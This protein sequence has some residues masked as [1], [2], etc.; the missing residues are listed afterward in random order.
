MSTYQIYL[1]KYGE[2]GVVQEVNHPIVVVT[3]LPTVHYQEV[4]IF[5]NNQKGQIFSLGKDYVEVLVFSREPI[6][7]GTKVAK[8]GKSIDVPIGD[9]LLGQVINPLGKLVTTAEGIIHPDKEQAIDIRPLSIKQRIKITDSLLTGVSIVDLM[10]PLGKGQRELITGDRKTGKS[11]FLFTVVKNQVLQGTIIIYAAIG[12]KAVEIEHYRQLFIQEKL[13]KNIVMVVSSALEAQSM[14][15]ITPF[16]AMTIAEYFKDI[17]RNVLVVLDDLSTHAQF[18]REISLLAKHFPGRESYPADIFYTHARLL[19]RAGNY[20]SSSGE[21]V[22]ITCLPV[23]ETIENDL[24]NYIVSNLIGITDGHLL[25][26]V[27]EFAKGRR[28]A[29]NETLSVTRVGR[30]TQ[31]LLLQEMGQQVYSFLSAYKK[32]EQYAHFGAELTDEIKKNLDK[33]QKLYA[34][35]NQPV[36]LVMPIQLQILCLAMIWLDMFYNISD[37]KIE[38]VRERLYKTYWEKEEFKSYIDRL[39]N[40]VSFND[41]KTAIQN[42]QVKIAEICDFKAK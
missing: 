3:G 40:M 15:Y 39:T 7:V 35:F 4:V 41:L 1:E 33:G 11:S 32:Q 13:I 27:L 25:F 37:K 34:F 42:E 10:L 22:S 28:P 38:S 31:S 21:E 19:E 36:N 23:A 5:E 14:I 9:Y 29:I 17:G 16:T 8:T 24:T 12:K 18:Y 26:D 2:F 20:R 30:Q 6:R